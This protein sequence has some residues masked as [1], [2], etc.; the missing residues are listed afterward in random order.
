MR[1]NLDLALSQAREDRVRLASRTGA[2]VS[3]IFDFLPEFIRAPFGRGV[4]VSKSR[5]VARMIVSESESLKL[6]MNEMRGSVW[7]ALHD[8]GAVAKLKKE[9]ENPIRKAAAEAE[10]RGYGNLRFL[11]E[12]DITKL[13][14]N[15]ETAIESMQTAC[16][17]SICRDSCETGLEDT[18]IQG[19]DTGEKKVIRRLKDAAE[20]PLEKAKAVVDEKELE[21][22]RS[23]R[24]AKEAKIDLRKAE[25]ESRIK[26]AKAEK[27]RAAVKAASI[28]ARLAKASLRKLKTRPAPTRGL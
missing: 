16:F 7:K 21:A 12:D 2:R 27:D 8:L 5:K 26:T 6:R 18:F 3:G 19:K 14:S 15:M 13:R 10:L 1:V 4:A 24:E 20:K 9:L 28:R 11:S 23:E 22:D 25:I 17:K